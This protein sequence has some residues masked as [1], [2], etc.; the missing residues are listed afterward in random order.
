MKRKR[1]DVNENVGEKEVKKKKKVDK[2]KKNS[3]NAGA[4]VNQSDIS[5]KPKKKKEKKI[6]DEDVQ[7]KE[8][9]TSKDTT[10]K[11]N[12]KKKKNDS[13]DVSTIGSQS[14]VSSKPKRKKEKKI[15]GEDAQLK[16]SENIGGEVEGETSKDSPVN[17]NSKKKKMRLGKRERAGLKFSHLFTHYSSQSTLYRTQRKKKGKGR[18]K[19]T[20]ISRI[21]SKKKKGVNIIFLIM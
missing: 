15:K 5:S 8:G 19:E 21:S 11:Q 12:S 17:P 14:D 1:D 18:T 20:Q 10:M 4:I 3:E 7:L 16:E 9:E 6:K 2:K 13:E